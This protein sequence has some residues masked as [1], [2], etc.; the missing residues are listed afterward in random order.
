MFG[1]DYVFYL[2]CNG[3]V[4][5]MFC[6][7]LLTNEEVKYNLHE[8]AS[9]ELRYYGDF[10][11]AKLITSIQKYYWMANCR[12]Y[13]SLTIYSCFKP[14]GNNMLNTPDAVFTMN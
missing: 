14:H 9:D 5:K 6:A 8:H 1:I 3:N 13:I 4:R 2:Y 10:S 7:H 12:F 11:S